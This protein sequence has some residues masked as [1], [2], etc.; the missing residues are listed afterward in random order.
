MAQAVQLNNVSGTLLPPTITGP[1]FQKAR[2]TSAVMSL[3]RRVPLALLVHQAVD[4]AVLG[5]EIRFVQPL[6][7][8]QRTFDLVPVRGGEVPE[9]EILLERIDINMK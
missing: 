4:R 2:E 7:Q 1:I 3:A 8:H 6:S 5:P 9:P